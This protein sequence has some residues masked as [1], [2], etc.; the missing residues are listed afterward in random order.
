MDC[1]MCGKEV[2]DEGNRMY[3][4]EACEDIKNARFRAKQCQFCGEYIGDI[5]YKNTDMEIRSDQHCP[6]CKY[7]GY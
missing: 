4:H 3:T 2:K 7:V 6:D 5:Y 1:S